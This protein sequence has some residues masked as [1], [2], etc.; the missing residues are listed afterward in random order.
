M[1]RFAFVA[2]LLCALVHAATVSNAQPLQQQKPLVPEQAV[3]SP[4]VQQA[5]DASY[6]TDDERAAMR[7]FHGVWD[8][9]DLRSPRDRA[10]AALQVGRYDDAVFED[11][12][13]PAMLRAEAALRR[14]EAEAVLVLLAED[15]ASSAKHLRAQAYMALGRHEQA[16]AVAGELVTLLGAE[17][18]DPH[19]LTSAA[20]GAALSARLNGDPSARYQQ[21]IRTL[22]RVHQEVDRLYWPALVAEAAILSDKHND[23]EAVHALHEALSLNP[24]GGEAWYLLGRIALR[25]FDFGSARV[26]AAQLQRLNPEHPLATLLLAE[27]RIVEDDPDEAVERLEA[28]LVRYPKMQRARALLAAAYAVH[29]DFDS[30]QDVLEAMDA[31][32][33]QCAEAYCLVGTHLLMNYQYPQAE[34]LLR[35]AIRREPAW[36]APQMELAQLE[37]QR[38][39]DQTACDMFLALRDLDPFNLRVVNTAALIEELVEYTTIE[40][41]NFI[42][43]YR[44]GIDAVVA[45]MM[46]QRLERIHATVAGRFRHEP[47]QKT[48]I[49]LMPDH[50]RFAVRLTGMPRVHTIAACTGPVIAMEVPRDGSPRMHNGVFDW[51]RVVQH[52]YTHTITLSQT[53]NRIPHWFTEAAAVSMEQAPRTYDRCRLLASAL[54]NDT[55]FELDEINWGFIRPRR[56]T[57]RAQAYAQANWMLEYMEHRFGPQS[58]VDLLAQYDAGQSDEGAFVNVFG[59]GGDQFMR[60]FRRWANGEVES[61]GLLASPSLDDLINDALADDSEYQLM[62]LASKRARLTAIGKRLVEEIGRPRTPRTKRLRARDWPSLARPPYEPTDAQ[63]DAWLTAHPDHPDL[64]ELRLRRDIDRTGG[65]GEAQ[66]DLLHRYARARP[67]DPYPHKKLVQYYRT[68]DQLEQAAPSLEFL[69]VREEYTA[70]YALE[71]A[72]VYRHLGDPERARAKALRA[73]EINP[74]DAPTR[75]LAAALAIESRQLESARLHIE[76]LTLIEPDRPLHQQRLER[77]DAMIARQAR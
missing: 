75:E 39:N 9:R 17:S 56:P 26:A 52:E 29:Y 61:W 46:P 47:S 37:W 13:V 43:R 20:M 35:E 41:D 58:V 18:D 44:P 16:T 62:L 74:Y 23:R 50:P 10:W 72:R 8:D 71:L 31:R 19:V 7:V 51:P 70:V 24:R 25:R 5:I 11:V 6:R 76:A 57:D 34:G 55:L 15:T 49:E 38:G 22:G 60:D 33:P 48:H 36:A 69:D 59:I 2:G 65:V 63:V 40:T 14:G 28:L 67:V 3:L 30:M 1:Q 21:V 66:L 64:L 77:L 54:A 53:S 32:A 73:V 45:Q 42:I 4:T 12:A 68:T 27:T